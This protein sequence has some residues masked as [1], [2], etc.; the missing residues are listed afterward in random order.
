MPKKPNTAMRAIHAQAV[1]ENIGVFLDS[2]RGGGVRPPTIFPKDR[3]AHRLRTRRLEHSRWVIFLLFVVL[4]LVGGRRVLSR[5]GALCRQ[6]LCFPHAVLV[7][8][9]HA[10][11]G[12]CATSA[13]SA[14]ARSGC[15]AALVNPALKWRS[16]IYG[17]SC[18]P[19]SLPSSHMGR[20]RRMKAQWMPF[21]SN[22]SFLHRLMDRP[23][24]RLKAQAAGK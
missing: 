13:I 6:S 9:I 10:N 18:P 21:A 14:A 16:A 7:A 8:L 1:A 11:N 4:L 19:I 17:M 15:L 5:V 23:H 20:D 12:G 2:C 3:L 24:R 22:Y